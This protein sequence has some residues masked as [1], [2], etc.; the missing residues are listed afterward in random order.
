MIYIEVW[1]EV[2][3]Y[4]QG[5][6]IRMNVLIKSRWPQWKA[7]GLGQIDPSIGRSV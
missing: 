1:T 7:S 5:D 3:D 2:N 6:N 4:R